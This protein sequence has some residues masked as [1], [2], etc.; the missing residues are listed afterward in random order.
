MKKIKIPIIIIILFTTIIL[1]SVVG[2]S[3]YIHRQREIESSTKI[4]HA[5]IVSISNPTTIQKVIIND[6]LTQNLNISI[7]LDCNIDAVV[8]VKISP[9]YFDSFERINLLPNNVTYS[10]NAS[11]GSW[12]PDENNMCFYFDSS[13]KDIT[14]LNFI[15]SISFDNE[16]I[17][18]YENHSVDFIIEA[19]ILQ[20]NTIDYNNHPWKDNAPSTWIEKI[21]NI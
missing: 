15:D 8:R 2:V 14:V 6:G 13:V 3:A 4:G 9:R 16:T 10:F 11:Q 18:E 12:I 5:Q 17:N 7:N 1:S 20:T 19:D 21:K